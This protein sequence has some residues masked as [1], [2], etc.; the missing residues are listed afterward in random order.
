MDLVGAAQMHRRDRLGMRAA[1]VRR[2]AGGDVPD[3]G[4]LGGDDRHMRRGDHR[5]APAR[6]IAADP[7]DRDVAMAEHHA[8]Q[9][10][11]LDIL[12]AR[13]AGSRRNCGSAPARIRCRRW[14]AATPWRRAPRSRRRTAES[15]AA[16]ICR[17]APTIRA[18]PRRR[19]P[20]TS[21]MMLS[22][23]PRTL[24]SA[25][26]WLPASAPDLIWRGIRSSTP[27]LPVFAGNQQAG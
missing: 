25:S 14:S 21:A 11:D 19:A 7:A 16:T 12:Q 18:P 4:D 27:V 22:T 2:G 13:R 8:G 9:G 3:P 5:V 26:S 23:V 10:L 17:S 20:A 1:L 6:H 15:S 24:A